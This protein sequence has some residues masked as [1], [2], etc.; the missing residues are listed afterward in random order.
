MAAPDQSFSMAPAQNGMLPV[1]APSRVL[2]LPNEYRRPHGFANVL[3]RADFA[4]ITAGSERRG[5]FI[6]QI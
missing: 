5:N 6:K 2:S 3:E 4:A 1:C